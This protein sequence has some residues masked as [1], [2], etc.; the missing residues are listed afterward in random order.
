MQG[1]VANGIGREKLLTAL[2]HDKETAKTIS[3]LLAKSMDKMRVGRE[4]KEGNGEGDKELKVT[5]LQDD[6]RM[7]SC[8]V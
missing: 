7:K 5:G 4:V 8:I 6:G 2:G 1:S 3:A